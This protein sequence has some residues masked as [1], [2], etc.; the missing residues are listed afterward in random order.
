MINKE[1]PDFY[2]SGK[3]EEMLDFIPQG[4]KK[5]LEVGC[6][7]GYFLQQLKDKFNAE[8]WGVEYNPVIAEKA[9][10]KIDIVI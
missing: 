8:A 1:K 10:K 4:S 2:Y 7:E 6:G 5:I 9:E 3:R